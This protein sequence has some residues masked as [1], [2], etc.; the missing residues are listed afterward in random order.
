M[1]VSVLNIES[2]SNHRANTHSQGQT[3][4]LARRLVDV[5]REA[6]WSASISKSQSEG[7]RTEIKADY[8]GE[9]RM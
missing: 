3:L 7:K 2:D 8:K 1:Q 9:L 4:K 5:I 6:S